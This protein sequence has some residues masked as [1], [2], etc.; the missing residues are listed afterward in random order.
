MTQARA[1][2]ATLLA[3]SLI[4]ASNPRPAR[5][6]EPSAPT[7]TDEP[8]ADATTLEARAHH[9]RAL[10]LYDDG[11]YRLALVEFERAYA[12]GKSYKVLFNI[13]QVSYQLTRYAKARV[14]FE[15]YLADGGN[16]V[17]TDRR[18]AVERDLTT[19]KLRT[20]SLS[21]HVNGPG[22][23]VVINDEP[24]GQAP[25]DDA[26]VDAGALRV[27]I[28]RDGWTPAVRQVTLAGGD[29]QT[30]D[31]TLSPVRREVI[32]TRPS[33]T[34]LSGPAL[35]GWI[36]TGVL[37]AGAIGTGIAANAASSTYD[38]KLNSPIAGSPAD[39]HADLEH[40]R[41]VVRGLAITTDALIVGSLIAGG[42][43][44]WLTIRGPHP[45]QP[46]AARDPF[47]VS[48]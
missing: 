9:R 3:T 39:A 11:E 29:S 36:A 30:L 25:I 46:H 32:E 23:T 27:N 6:D 31:V 14:A 26:I 18:A 44:L 12:I 21:I 37:A 45:D 42:I 13:G 40:Q 24:A 2:I 7:E 34:G 16:R 4:A 28:S 41:N 17:D 8:T 1:A 33:G 35:A 5:A 48:F 15:R 43:A 38:T 47:T 20:A 19:L 22:A 10:Q